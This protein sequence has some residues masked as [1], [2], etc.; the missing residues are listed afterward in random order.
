[1][2]VKGNLILFLDY[3]GVFL[4]ENELLQSLMFFPTCFHCIKAIVVKS[5]VHGRGAGTRVKR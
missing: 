4:K 3:M 1:M 2:L 5:W